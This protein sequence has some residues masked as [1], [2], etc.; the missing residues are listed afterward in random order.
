MSKKL[1]TLLLS[2]FMATSMLVG[3]NNE[4]PTAEVETTPDVVETNNHDELVLG[5]GYEPEGGFDP[6]S[7]SGHYG[8]SLFQSAL[9]KR[10][11]DL[12]VVDDLATDYKI[13]DD[14]LQYTVTIR[15]DALWSDDEKVTSKDVVF[16]YDLA[17][18]EGTA[19]VDLT[20]LLEVEPVDDYT[21]LFTLKEPDIGFVSKMISLGI[22]PEHCYG[23]D[24]GEHP[25]GCGPFKFVEWKK[26]Q[27]LITEPNENYYGDKVPF[28]KVTFLFLDPQTQVT[29]AKAKAAD[30]VR[31]PVTE[32]NTEFEGYHLETLKTM[33][34][35]GVSFPFVKRSGEVTDDSTI[36]PGSVIG[37]DITS[38]IA[39]RKAFDIAIDR[40]ALIDGALNGHG[41]KASSICDGMPW[42]NE[43]TAI[44]ND[45]DIEGAIKILEDAGWMLNEDG[46]R[47]KDGMVADLDLWYAY[48][49]R[50]NI[51]LAF[52]ETGNK[53][54]IHITPIYAEWSEVEPKMYSELVLFGWGGYDPLELY[55]SYSSTM[56]GKEYYNTNYY[57]NEVVDDYFNKALTAGSEEEAYDYFKKAQYDGTTGLSGMGD[58]PWVWMVNENHLYLVKDGLDIGKQ[59]VQPHGGG[60]PVL[61]TISNWKWTE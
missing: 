24:Y 13:S 22:V 29:T 49:D 41:T 11:V 59:K 43:E 7:G 47:E 60:W 40:Q 36:A 15:D 21:V 48:K 9:F 61:D 16:T 27:Q 33:D 58:C 57:S 32:A 50:E 6:I 42:F 28:E 38:D 52:A 2:G 44:K 26:G 30:V 18:Q 55:Y 20:N 5:L 12:N 34:N 17:K 25:V 45:G 54:G 1:M 51:A 53:L 4:K 31:I 23:D 37:N 3:C 8:T 56:R 39:I 10:D 35:R 19:A 46:I 14:R